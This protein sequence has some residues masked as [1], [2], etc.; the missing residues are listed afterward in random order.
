M[1]LT[2]ERVHL[3]LDP[4]PVRFYQQ[5]DSTNDLAMEWLRSG[6]EA[7][8]VVIADEQLKGRGRL[9]RAW[10]TP[11]GSALAL[12]VVLRPG[13]GVLERVSMLGALAV[14]EVLDGLE[15]DGVGLKWPNDVQIG[16]LKVCGVLPEAAW[17]GD[18]LIGVVLGIGVN[19]SVDFSGTDLER[20]A[21][22]IAVVLGQPVDRLH[23]LEALLDRIDFWNAR[24][25]SAVLVESWQSR[26]TTIGQAV[27]LNIGDTRVSGV[28]ETVDHQ[29]ALWVRDVQGAL[30]RVM[31][32]DIALG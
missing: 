26:L 32:G 16:G 8:A 22:S 27:S 21:G 11:P 12:S 30:H 5:V 15:V 31:A 7:G 23:L 4:R 1:R 18:H 20:S 19:V 14:C 10:R 29:G 13:P 6:A 2:A 17:D 28:A 3:A 24:L 9:G 25:E